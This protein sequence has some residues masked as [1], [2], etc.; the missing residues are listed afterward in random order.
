MGSEK[1]WIYLS[2]IVVTFL[3]SWVL[4]KFLTLGFSYLQWRNPQELGVMSRTA[5]LSFVVTAVAAYGYFRQEKVNT[6][7]ME[8]LQELKKVTWTPRKTVSLST[9]VVIILVFVVSIVIGTF[10]WMCSHLIGRMLGI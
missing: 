10:D 1:K 4:N 7:S 9:M 6:F 2:Y 8:V 3:V 5:I